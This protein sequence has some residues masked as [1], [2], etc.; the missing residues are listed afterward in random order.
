VLLVEDDQVIQ[1]LAAM[2]PDHPFRDC[3]RLWRVNRG[4]GVDADAP[5]A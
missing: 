1:A 3:I 5:G 2:G 4:D